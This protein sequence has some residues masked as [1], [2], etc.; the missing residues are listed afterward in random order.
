MLPV[1]FTD[2]AM[3]GQLPSLN[4]IGFQNYNIF[5]A[6]LDNNGFWIWA[7]Q[8]GS[9]GNFEFNSGNGIAVDYRGNVYT[10]G[11]LTSP[12]TFRSIIIDT[13]SG[14][15]LFIAKQNDDTQ[16]NLIGIAQASGYIGQFIDAKFD[17]VLPEMFIQ[18]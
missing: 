12:A 2:T 16:I 18:I 9:S 8:A 14:E 10:T 5:T 13:G 17:T 6:K 15:S 11:Q 7:T 1:S 4:T 3:F